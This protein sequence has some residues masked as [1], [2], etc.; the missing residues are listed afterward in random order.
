MVSFKPSSLE[1]W[2]KSPL[3][4]IAYGLE[5]SPE[6]VGT[7]WT[8]ESSLPLP[9]IE[10]RQSIPSCYGTGFW[11]I[12]LWGMKNKM[13]VN[14][15]RYSGLSKGELSSFEGSQ[16]VL[17]STCGNGRLQRNWSLRNWASLWAEGKVEQGFTALHLSFD[18]NVQGAEVG[19]ALRSKG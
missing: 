16:A 2:G 4:S 17:T 1:T 13:S 5:W 12:T 18:R 11:Y 19:C 10:P 15:G 6:S 3:V 14:S 8:T 9:E 7:L